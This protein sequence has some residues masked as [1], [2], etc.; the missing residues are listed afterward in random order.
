MPYNEMPYNEAP[1]N[2]TPYDEMPYDEMPPKSQTLLGGVSI[3]HDPILGSTI[4]Y[5]IVVLPMFSA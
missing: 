5:F 2:E 4:T 3:N 1:C